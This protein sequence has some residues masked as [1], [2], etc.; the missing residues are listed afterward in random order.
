MKAAKII[1]GII[2]LLISMGFLYKPDTIMKIN[3]LARRYIF[4]DVWVLSHRGKTGVLF[5][6]LALIALYMGVTAI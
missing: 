6:V 3:D 5:F 1:I 2:L 4:N